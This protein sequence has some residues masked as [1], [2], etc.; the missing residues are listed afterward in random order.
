VPGASAPAATPHR[1]SQNRRQVPRDLHRNSKPEAGVTPVALRAA[2]E[3]AAMRFTQRPPK[4]GPGA[5]RPEAAH[6]DC[7]PTTGDARPNTFPLY[8]ESCCEINPVEWVANVVK[9]Q[10]RTSAAGGRRENRGTY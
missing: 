4:V 6:V 9:G 7:A 1:A 10:V 8:P 2:S 3:D 5:S